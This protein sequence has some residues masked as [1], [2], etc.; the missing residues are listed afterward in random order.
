MQNL[1]LTIFLFLLSLVVSAQEVPEKFN[2]E[3]GTWSL[4]GSFN[5]GAAHRNFEDQDYPG[6]YDNFSF[7]IR[8][9]VG[10]FLADNL[11]GGVRF[12]YGYSENNYEEPSRDQVKSHTFMFSPYLRKFINLSSK[13]AFSVTGSVNYTIHQRD[14]YS[15]DEHTGQI[16]SQEYGVIASP[17]VYFLLNDRFTLNATVGQ[18]YYRYLESSRDGE[19]IEST[20]QYG[21]S[22]NFNHIFLGLTYYIN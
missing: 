19:D 17:G 9:E 14:D 15:A 13:F 8:P 5:F 3:Q 18:L 7:G 6:D 22:A 4:G 10:Y 2:I 1:I 21:L 16:R 12:G 11:E 20:N